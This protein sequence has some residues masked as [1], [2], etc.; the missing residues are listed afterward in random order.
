MLRGILRRENPT[1]VLIAA[2]RRGF[3][4]V[5]FTADRRNNFVGSIYALPS[6]LVS[7]AF[8]WRWVL[9]LFQCLIER[10]GDLTNLT[11]FHWMKYCRWPW[12]A[13][14][15]HFRY[16]KQ[17]DCLCLK[18]T[19]YIMYEVNYNGRTS[20]VSSYFCCHVQL[21][22]CYMMLEKLEW[23]GYL[24]VKNV[25]VDMFT[26]LDT[27]HECD[28]RTDTALWHRPRLHSIAR[29]R[30]TCVFSMLLCSRPVGGGH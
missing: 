9:L 27:L 28:G 16:H 7:A 3:T 21:E 26:R 13:F 2:A 4:M 22:D 10:Q 8:V 18:N 29:Q 17:F 20:C 23:S 1:Y 15:G 24:R 11:I 30:S 14:E 5:L 19:A 12:M 6:V 25:W